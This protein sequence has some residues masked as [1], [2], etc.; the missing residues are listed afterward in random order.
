MLIG[1][2]GGDGN[3]LLNV[4]PRPDGV[5]DPE[6]ASRLKDVGDWLAKYGES[7]Y[8]TRGGPYKPGDWGASTRKGNRI[9]IHVLKWNGDP[10][11]LPALPAKIMAAKVLTGGAVDFKQTDTALTL[12]VPAA[13]HA[14]ID[15]LIALDIDNPAMDIAPINTASNLPASK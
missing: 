5:I 14:E 4:G 10:L 6:Q 12:T 13:A 1:G 9:Y 8:G 3:I 7:I 15:T 2:A 11:Q